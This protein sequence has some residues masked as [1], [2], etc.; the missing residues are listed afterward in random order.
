MLLSFYQNITY[1]YPFFVFFNT[2]IDIFLFSWY[3]STNRRVFEF[4]AVKLKKATLE[5]VGLHFLHNMI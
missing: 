3:N 2:H 5:K 4:F 1:L